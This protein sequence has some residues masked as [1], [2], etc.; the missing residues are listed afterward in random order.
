MLGCTRSIEAE[1][2]S[3]GRNQPGEE[4][5]GASHREG[6]VSVKDPNQK[7]LHASEEQLEHSEQNKDQCVKAQLKY[8][9]FTGVFY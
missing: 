9:F 3:V 4:Q 1:I 5:R 8:P 6:T 7:E 2:W